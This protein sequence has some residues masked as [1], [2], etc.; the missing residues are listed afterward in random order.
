[1]ANSSGVVQ[2]AAELPGNFEHAASRTR[3]RIARIA[4]KIELGWPGGR[5]TLDFFIG[6]RR[7]GRSYAF[8]EDGYLYQAPVGYYATRRAWDMAPGYESDARPDL[9]RPITSD[10]L[11]CHAGGAR[12]SR[13]TLNRVENLAELHGVTCERCHGAGAEHAARPGAGSIRN[14]RKLRASARDAVCE[15][16]H[17]AGAV[18]LSLPG[19][20]PAKF[21]PGEE[22]SDYVEV[23]V[24]SDAPR[25]VRVNGHAEALAASKCR[26]SA[27]EKLW[28]GT[29]HSPHRAAAGFRDKCL[30][31]HRSAQ[32]PSPS[33]DEG[34]CTRC[35][36]PKAT[37]YDGGHTV[38]TDHS[39]PRRPR[40]P[41]RRDNAPTALLPYY[42]RALPETVARRNLGLAY[43]ELGVQFRRSAL[44]EKAWPLLRSAAESEPRDPALYTRMAS[45]LQA[46]GRADQA[47][48]LY[49]RSLALDPNQ[50]SALMNLAGLLEA[51]GERG[52]AAELRRRAAVLLPRQPGW[53]PRS[54]IRQE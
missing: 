35:H 24:S 21:Q 15:Q 11:F 37:A 47:I 14:P 2:A 34:D 10:C 23:F 7:M 29:C 52:Q 28:C 22:L 38:F 4:D 16:C 27:P 40:N 9:D 30:E 12:V 53:R 51:R 3:Y 44:L 1:M 26:Q 17:L 54:L 48:E 31:C 8:S 32:C 39:I 36:M 25:G 13:G 42:R 33:R 19:A 6:S 43:A 20:D 5:V 18:R 49:R 46:D 41:T 50:N 45:L